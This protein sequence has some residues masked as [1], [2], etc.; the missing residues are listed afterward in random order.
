MGNPY[1]GA[2]YDSP[3]LS[4][5][6]NTLLPENVSSVSMAMHQCDKDRFDCKSPSISVNFYDVDGNEVIVNSTD[7]SSLYTLTIPLNDVTATNLAC[8]F[9]VK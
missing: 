8:K 6:N 2:A 9:V 1:T 3:E 4:A 5:V 7:D